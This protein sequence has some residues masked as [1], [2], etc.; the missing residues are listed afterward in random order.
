MSKGFIKQCLEENPNA[1]F[2]VNAYDLKEF[3]LDVIKEYRQSTPDEQYLTVKETIDLL[4]ISRPTLKSFQKR[5]LI[6]PVKFG[7]R[8]RYPVSEVNR[9]IGR[10]KQL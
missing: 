9:F 8:E 2:A 10:E 5:G 1:M 4:G 7:C 6:T 3:V